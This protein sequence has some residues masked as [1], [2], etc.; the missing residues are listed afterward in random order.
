MLL[1]SLPLLIQGFLPS[2]GR[3]YTQNKTSQNAGLNGAAHSSQALRP[4]RPLRCFF[5]FGKYFGIRHCELQRN[6]GI[7]L[8]HQAYHVSI[9]YGG[10]DRGDVARRR[11]VC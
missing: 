7:G 2:I 1:A 6:H 5:S 9:R 11:I 8:E 10:K 3:L 4:L